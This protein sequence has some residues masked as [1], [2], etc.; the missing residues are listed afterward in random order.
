MPPAF[1]A[2]NTTPSM[3]RGRPRASPPTPPLPRE[4]VEAPA[5]SPPAPGTPDRLEPLP[6]AGPAGLCTTAL[7]SPR[8]GHGAPH[9]LWRRGGESAEHDAGIDRRGVDDR[10]AARRHGVPPDVERV[11]PAELR[12]DARERIVELAVEQL[13][14]DVGRGVGDFR[15]L[16]CGG[17]HGRSSLS[18]PSPP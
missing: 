5:G 8:G 15:L 13:P 2:P 11:V 1:E 9:L 14:V 18:F 4:E 12:P 10:G 6:F 3:P 7:S 17:R 16:G